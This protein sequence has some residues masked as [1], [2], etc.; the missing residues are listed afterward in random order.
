MLNRL[1]G[2]RYK[3]KAPVNPFIEQEP[4][5]LPIVPAAEPAV[6]VAESPPA[7]V[8]VQAPVTPERSEADILREKAFMEMIDQILQVHGH[9]T[10][11]HHNF[12]AQMSKLITAMILTVGDMEITG[13]TL[14][15]AEDHGVST[16]ETENGT[17][18][19]TLVKL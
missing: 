18:L 9:I 17:L 10:V 4:T 16:T 14:Q 19:V 11:E 15:A 3:K 1:F 6:T 2:N 5:P 7:L 13:E 8:T 12:R